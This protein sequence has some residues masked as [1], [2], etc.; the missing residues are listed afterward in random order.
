MTAVAPQTEAAE[1]WCSDDPPVALLV[2]GRPVTVQTFFSVPVRQREELQHARV[3]GEVRGSTIIIRAVVPGTP[4]RVFSKIPA[5][6]RSAG[7]RREVHPAGHAVTLRFGGLTP[8]LLDR[9]GARP[10]P[11]AAAPLVGDAAAA[12]DAV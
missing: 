4:F 5:L 10:V 11:G 7:S 1:E 12:G 6:G 3:T 8:V 9:L 2:H